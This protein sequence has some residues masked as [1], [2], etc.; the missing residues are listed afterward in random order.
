ML[1]LPIPII[2][3]I[4]LVALSV[5]ITIRSSS[6]SKA[7]PPTNTDSREKVAQP[8]RRNNKE[9]LLTYRLRGIPSFFNI[10]KAEQLIRTVLSLTAGDPVAVPSLAADPCRDAAYNLAHDFIGHLGRLSICT[11]L[12]LKICFSHRAFHE[13]GIPDISTIRV[14]DNNSNDIIQYWTNR[15]NYNHMNEDVIQ[16]IEKE[17]LH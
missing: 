6:R 7:R 17:V 4:V 11:K 8:G 16:E 12:R 14:D 13:L 10:E 9:K 1:P 15:I 3:I 5:T 2:A